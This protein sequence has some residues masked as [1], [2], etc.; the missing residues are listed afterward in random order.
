MRHGLSSRVDA[1]LDALEGVRAEA[2]VELLFGM[3]G[4]LGTL[5]ELVEVDEAIELAFEAAAEQAL[6]AVVVAGADRRPGCD[7][8]PAGDRAIGIAARRPGRQASW[9]RR[10]TAS[11]GELLRDAVRARRVTSIRLLDQ[12]LDGVV[13]VRG[14]LDEAFE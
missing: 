12:L 1:F 7:R 4:V 3:Q 2:G 5:L 11:G 10:F 6:S 8:A 13:L 9:L 14:G